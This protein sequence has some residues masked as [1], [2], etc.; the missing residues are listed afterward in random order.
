MTGARF[1]NKG[2]TGSKRGGWVGKG[3]A[4]ADA[5][6]AGQNIAKKR[7]PECGAETGP[8][9]RGIMKIF[10]C[11]AHRHKYH[12][13][14]KARGQALVPLLLAWR[15]GRGGTD[16]ARAAWQEL[17]TVLD[18]FAAEDRAEGRPP[19]GEYVSRLLWMGRHIDRRRK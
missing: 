9:T 19:P 5:S 16:V 8:G 15:T 14:S 7:C 12:A 13:R 3:R 11:A 6:P 10:C 1:Q 4:K 17:N 18:T 2:D